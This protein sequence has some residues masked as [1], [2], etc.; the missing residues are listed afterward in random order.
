M[1]VRGV[2]RSGPVGINRSMTLHQIKRQILKQ[3][4]NTNSTT[5]WSS[6]YRSRSSIYSRFQLWLDFLL[7]LTRVAR[8]LRDSFSLA[9]FG[10]GERASQGCEREIPRSRFWFFRQPWKTWSK[11]GEAVDTCQ[12]PAGRDNRRFRN[13]FLARKHLKVITLPTDY[14]AVTTTNR[15]FSSCALNDDVEETRASE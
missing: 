2:C 5:S 13:S 14:L 10:G 7:T 15:Y 12:I 3:K 6:F 11:H 9:T 8:R 4:L 1:W